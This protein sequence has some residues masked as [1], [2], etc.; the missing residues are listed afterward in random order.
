MYETMSNDAKV[1]LY[2]GSTK[3]TPLS[4]VLRPMKL[5]ATNGKTD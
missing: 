1:L 4:T 3:F 2:I 5:K